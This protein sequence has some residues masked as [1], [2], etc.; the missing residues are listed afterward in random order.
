[1]NSVKL[2]NLKNK[3]RMNLNEKKENII[4]LHSEICKYFI[5]LCENEKNNFINIFKFEQLSKCLLHQVEN[6]RFFEKPD[7]ID[8][9]EKNILLCF[10]K[11]IMIKKEDYQIKEIMNNLFNN[12]HNQNMIVR[13][14]SIK[15]LISLTKGLQEGSILFI[16][17]IIPKL[18]YVLDDE[19]QEVSV[20]CKVLIDLMQSFSNEN[21]QE[22]IING[23]PN[24]ES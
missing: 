15:V 1:M 16:N 14:L 24:F 12:F 8:Y 9:F 21:I 13:L 7:L 5:L 10:E 20:E 23:V 18:T 4:C 17:D 19:V 11:I 2:E 22:F 3:K 6:F